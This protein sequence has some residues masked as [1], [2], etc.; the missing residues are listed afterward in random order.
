[1]DIGAS[2]GLPYWIPTPP[3]STQSTPSV[4]SYEFGATPE[5]SDGQPDYFLFDNAFGANHGN[6]LGPNT[7]DITCEDHLLGNG[8]EC[9]L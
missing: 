6:M 1:M 8:L 9:L 7:S 2:N 3:L 5:D 4:E